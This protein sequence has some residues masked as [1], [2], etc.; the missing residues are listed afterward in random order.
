[1]P[2]KHFLVDLSMLGPRPT[3]VQLYAV[4]VAHHLERSFVCRILSPRHLA[5]RFVD[6]VECGGPLMLRNSVVA[7]GWM[8]RVAHSLVS[9]GE[10]F[11]YCP[12]MRG[13]VR[14]RNQVITIHDLIAHRYPTRNPIERAFNRHVLPR[15]ARRVRG[16]FTVSETAR[17]D[18]SAFY[19]LPARRVHVVPNG[20]DLQ[21]WCP[22][23]PSRHSQSP[24]LLVVSANRPYKNTTELLLHHRLWASRYRVKIVSSRAR[25]GRVI[26]TAVREQGLEHVVDFLD[27]ISEPELI[28][29]YR[30]CAAVVYPSLV[31]GFGRPALEG[32]A[33]GR[34]VILSDIPV[35]KELFAEAAIFITPGDGGSW[36]RA[37]RELR[38]TA[39]LHG[40]IERG[41]ATARR[42][43][44]EHTYQY[45]TA[46]LLSVQPH[47]EMFRKA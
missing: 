16:V 22:S 9:S 23:V 27:D 13:F 7:R 17:K 39:H 8:S 25:Y 24:Y 30:G 26:R 46:A 37:F 47:L 32:M 3:G 34:P 4:D 21:T 42:Y 20:L 43:S 45:L 1:M 15:L 6:P 44:L 2:L 14:Q 28:E 36:D 35:H 31:E 19:D 11:I 41:I 40:R 29:L 10:T 12:Y 5:S 33:V 18:I 38:D